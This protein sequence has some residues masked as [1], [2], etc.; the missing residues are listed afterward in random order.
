MQGEDA[1]SR[2]LARLRTQKRCLDY[3]AQLVAARQGHILEVG[4]GKGR[5]YDRLRTLFPQRRIY[6]FD[7][8]VHC[9]ARL[10]P[11]A[12]QLFLGDFRDSLPA[13][14][15]RLGRSA[16]LAHVDLGTDDFARDCALAAAV[17]PLLDRLLLPDALVL[18][19]R[20]MDLARW[21]ALP[22]PAPETG[23]SYYLYRSVSGA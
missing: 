23:F 8:E 15:E 9:P 12:A 3:A 10:R 2:M 1:L 22:Q 18:S 13:A 7:R 16:A 20:P 6:A 11:A 19:D 17:A 5:S 14:F 4:L 21:A